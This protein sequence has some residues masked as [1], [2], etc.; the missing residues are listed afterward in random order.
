MISFLKNKKNRKFL[1]FL[2][3]LFSFSFSVVAASAITDGLDVFQSIVV[4]IAFFINSVAG[5]IFYYSAQTFD[6]LLAIGLS[7]D[8]FEADYIKII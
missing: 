4:A 1:F 7:V 3:I 5:F 8:F 2:L 6:N